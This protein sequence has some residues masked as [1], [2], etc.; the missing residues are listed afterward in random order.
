M[1]GLSYYSLSQKKRLVA[2]FVPPLEEFLDS[3][4]GKRYSARRFAAL[5]F[6]VPFETVSTSSTPK[7]V[8][9]AQCPA[10]QAV[11]VIGFNIGFDGT[12]STQGP[13][14]VEMCQSTYATNG[15]GT[16]STSVTP[17]KYDSGRPETIQT[18]AAKNWT[19]EPT[20]LTVVEAFLIPVYM[21]SGII[22]VPLTS[23]FVC[24]G[25][26]GVAMRI[27]LPSAVTANATGTIKCEE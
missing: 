21:G 9:G 27:T 19:S 1:R 4:K 22:Y 13:A 24:K 17:A 7:T 11:K 2:G 14:I 3:L 26:G 10:Q 20:V 8:A 23:P 18:T 5:Q 6:G 12:S 16:N 25:G 15:P